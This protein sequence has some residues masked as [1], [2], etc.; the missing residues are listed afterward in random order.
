MPGPH[1]CDDG[2]FWQILCAGNDHYMYHPHNKHWEDDIA[3]DTSPYVA[4]GHDMQDD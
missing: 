4:I 3:S 1:I 2:Q